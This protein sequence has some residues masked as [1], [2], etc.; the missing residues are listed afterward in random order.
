MN[1]ER[2]SVVVRER[3]PFEAID[4]GLAMAR[5]WSRDIW[6]TWLLAWLPLSILS[7]LVFWKV[8]WV[9]ALLVWWLKPL[10]DRTVL[11]VVSRRFFGERLGPLG[12]LSNPRAYLGGGLL[13]D[14]SFRRFTPFRSYLMPVDQLEQTASEGRRARVA[15]LAR[16]QLP[17]AAA[18]TALSI[19]F[20]LCFVLSLATLFA[21]LVPQ[22]LHDV[23][24]FGDAVPTW[25]PVGLYA[26]Y[27][28][29]VAILE[30]FYVAAG[31]A[32][33]INR[34]V[35]LEGWDIELGL[36][37][38]AHRLSQR[39]R[40]AAMTVLV[41][42]VVCS[43]TRPAVADV[44]APDVPTASARNLDP[45]EVSNEE[46]RN[47]PAQS[48][49]A[50]I[51]EV[52]ADP[53]FET[54]DV[55]GRWKLRS[56]PSDDPGN[57]W[58]SDWLSGV[59]AV[60]ASLFTWITAIVAIAILVAFAVI[61]L[62]VRLGE[63]TGAPSKAA[64]SQTIGGLDIRPE[65]LPSDV[66]GAARQRWDMGDAVGALSLLYRGILAFVVHERGIDIPSSATEEECV[67][68]LNDM[69]QPGFVD[70]FVVLTRAWQSLAYGGHAPSHDHF[71][72]LCQRWTACVRGQA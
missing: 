11:A 6:R 18:L 38:M 56:E 42:L 7:G 13:V 57:E 58:T 28:A 19:A 44:P 16:E 52:M 29:A 67:A 41:C 47:E 66:V 36:R 27:V 68:A 21:L 62:R 14:L 64:K 1:L 17:A 15:L 32:L 40:A 59:G 70:D 51:R 10:L 30:P 72:E 26:L 54:N 5:A 4:L 24:F 33:Y 9:A 60:L 46:R 31:F 8:P 39:A 22:Q 63:P 37:K 25:L 2:V 43:S 53:A 69:L 55:R 49:S 34:R 48:P 3:D 23:V 71:V 61:F 50:A 12:L 20:E 35:R 65:A 45:A